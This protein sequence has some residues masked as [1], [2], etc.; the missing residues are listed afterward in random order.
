MPP[1]YDGSWV[2]PIFPCQTIL[3][4]LEK[5][6]WS[7]FSTHLIWSLYL[8]T[9]LLYSFSFSSSIVSKA[10]ATWRACVLG[11]KA[12]LGMNIKSSSIV[13]LS[14]LQ[15][16]NA[17]ELDYSSRVIIMI[18]ELVHSLYAM[19]LKRTTLCLIIHIVYMSRI[20]AKLRWRFIVPSSVPM[21]Y[22]CRSVG[23]ES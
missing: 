7:S 8:T 21:S 6:G 19:I 18:Y 22:A 23:S 3:T 17:Y 16:S 15:Y 5:K 1:C 14:Y 2:F 12:T 11:R 10:R 13:M 20:R 9:Q 4:S